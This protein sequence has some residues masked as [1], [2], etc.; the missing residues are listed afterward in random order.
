MEKRILLLAVVLMVVAVYS[1]AAL[2]LAPMGPPMATLGEGQFGASVEYGYSDM[3][4][5]A[6]GDCEFEVH[7]DKVL[8]EEM[9]GT[10]ETELDI[11]DLQSHWIFGDIGYGVT[12]NL[13]AFVRLGAAN[14][15]D[16]M[17]G[18]DDDGD[19]IKYSGGYGFAWGFGTKVTLFQ[20]NNIS[21]GGLFQMTWANPGDD[22]ITVYSPIRK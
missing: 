17:G 14:A 21:W 10:E 6:K 2:A 19:G 15:E 3:D 7:V 16:E 8:I 4:L 20:D 5:E 18:D 13:E 11:K 9:S 22:D 12:D 1:S